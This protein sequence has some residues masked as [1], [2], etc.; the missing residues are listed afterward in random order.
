VAWV[1]GGLKQSFKTY[2]FKLVKQQL[3]QNTV[4][5]NGNAWVSVVHDKKI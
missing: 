1:G 3:V 4:S 2:I 5:E